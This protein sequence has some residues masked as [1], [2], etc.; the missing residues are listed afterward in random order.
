MSEQIFNP[1]AYAERQNTVA[2]NGE[3]MITNMN[4]LKRSSYGAVVKLPDFA[5]GYPFVAQLRRPSL[6]VLAKSGKIPN[7]LMSVANGLFV[8]GGTSL[9]RDDPDMLK[10]IYDIMTVIAEASL[11]QPT[12]QEIVAANVELTDEQLM[13]IFNYSQKGIKALE[14]FR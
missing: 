2:E 3:N 1:M 6:M 4:D 13:A 14:P 5:D 12:M 10:N 7:R 8:D 11:I 9:D